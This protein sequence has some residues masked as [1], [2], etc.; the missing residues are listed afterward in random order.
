MFKDE[1]D[2]LPLPGDNAK[3][4]KYIVVSR[5]GIEIREP[6]KSDARPEKVGA[7]G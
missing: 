2:R 3:W 5:G 7:R 6:D 1:N 4:S